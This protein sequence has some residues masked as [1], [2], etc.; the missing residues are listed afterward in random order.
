MLPSPPSSPNSR[1]S[2][3]FLF[4]LRR[5][6][7]FSSLRPTSALAGGGRLLQTFPGVSANFSP[8]ARG[9]QP[10]SGPAAAA[11]AWL[12][13]GSPARSGEAGK[14]CLGPASFP[15]G[16][17]GG[18]ERREPKLLPRGAAGS[19]RRLL[20]SPARRSSHGPSTRVS[21]R[22]NGASSAFCPREGNGGGVFSRPE[23]H[24]PSPRLSRRGDPPALSPASPAAPG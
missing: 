22:V 14:R 9:F 11:A 8:E 18:S 16:R 12:A 15:V 17:A 1:R 6:G 4:F 10:N 23:S 2:F 13:T 19:P 5:P 24:P 7:C 3:F 20:S 21:G